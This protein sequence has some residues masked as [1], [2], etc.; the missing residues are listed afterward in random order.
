MPTKMRFLLCI[1][2]V[3]ITIT[4]LI[5]IPA[6]A[7]DKVKITLATWTGVDEAKAQG[8]RRG[9]GRARRMFLCVH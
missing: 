6:R 9:R 8:V 5:G 3:T 4:G 1:L 2:L 7:A